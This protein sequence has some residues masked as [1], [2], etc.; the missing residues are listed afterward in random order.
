MNILLAEDE[1]I[2][3]KA[4]C[5]LLEAE[6]HHVDVA[7]NGKLAVERFSQSYDL[8]LMDLRMPEM[9][10]MEAVKAIRQLEK[11]GEHLPIIAV[12]GEGINM[13]DECLAAG[14]DDFFIKPLAMPQLQKWLK[15]FK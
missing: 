7:S 8:V 3:Q 11:R 12:T 14:F 13:Q 6:G 4:T 15:K 9:D 10:G 2:L 5:F 1:P